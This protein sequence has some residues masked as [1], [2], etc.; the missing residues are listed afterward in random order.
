MI[1]IA[2]R[3]D[4][5]NSCLI[6]IFHEWRAC[7]TLVWRGAPGALQDIFS[8]K[9]F[10]SA[11]ASPKGR[12]SLM[13]ISRRSGKGP[14]RKPSGQG[15]RS[16]EC[17]DGYF[18]DFRRLRCDYAGDNGARQQLKRGVLVNPTVKT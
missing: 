6:I 3:P 1:V 5:L 14:A 4:C 9:F 10:P 16:H 11:R 2:L 12:R 7:I 13:R 15:E 18:I 17:D 8:L